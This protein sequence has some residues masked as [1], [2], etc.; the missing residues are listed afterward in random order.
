M[1]DIYTFRFHYSE[2]KT[3]NYHVELDSFMKNV[4]IFN[5]VTFTNIV[6]KL[7]PD[8]KEYLTLACHY[9]S[10]Y[11]PGEVFQ[12]AIDSAVPCA[13]M[14][15]VARTLQSQLDLMRSRNDISLMVCASR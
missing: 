11:F 12:G 7:N 3:L 15:N 4:P 9:D 6:A 5:N 10:K 1:L 14:L 13:I 8:A 2:L